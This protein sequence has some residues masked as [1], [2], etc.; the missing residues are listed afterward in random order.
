MRGDTV[1]ESRGL[2]ALVKTGFLTP[3][4]VT[5]A[6]WLLRSLPP[7]AVLLTGGDLGTYGT[8]AMQVARSVP[9]DAAPGNAVLLSG[10]THSRPAPARA[11]LTD[12]PTSAAGPAG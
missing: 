7:R 4:Q 3:A 5:Y 10:R 6:E 12:E 11:P 8:L 2:S 9:P 1:M